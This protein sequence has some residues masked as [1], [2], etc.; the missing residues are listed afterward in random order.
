MTFTITNLELAKEDKVLEVSPAEVEM[1]FMDEFGMSEIEA[2]NFVS[3]ALDVCG[4]D[5]PIYRNGRTLV[6][7]LRANPLR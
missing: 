7:W 2:D 4:Q 3:D 1:S 6:G 5:C